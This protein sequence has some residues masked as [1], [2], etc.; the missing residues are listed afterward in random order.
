MQSD[1]PPR[2]RGAKGQAETG[3]PTESLP[4]PA[5]G[6]NRSPELGR[7]RPL[8]RRSVHRGAPPQSDDG[9]FSGSSSQYVIASR[10][11]RNT[12]LPAPPQRTEPPAE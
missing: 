11:A 12:Q 8:R 6:Q 3:K 1:D 9:M 7:R 10:Q 5:V 4:L 2:G